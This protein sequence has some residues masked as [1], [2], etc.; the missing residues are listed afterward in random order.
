M[1]SFL[2]YELVHHGLHH[3][4]LKARPFRLLRSHHRIHHQFPDRNFGVTM[5]VWDWV[6]GTHYLGGSQLR[7]RRAATR[8]SSSGPH[9]L[10]EPEG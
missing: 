1:I 10:Q 7:L 9:S 8:P 3:W 4:T 2:Y 6:F 5:T